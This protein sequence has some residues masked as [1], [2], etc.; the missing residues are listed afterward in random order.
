MASHDV[1]VSSYGFHAGCGIHTGKS[2]VKH[3][4]RLRHE[5]HCESSVSTHPC[6]SS[7]LV[8]LCSWTRY[9][10]LFITLWSGFTFFCYRHFITTL[11]DRLPLILCLHLGHR[12]LRCII[13][14]VCCIIL[15]RKI[16]SIGVLAHFIYHM[17]WLMLCFPSSLMIIV[18]FCIRSH[19]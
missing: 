8:N 1:P 14:V 16:T 13:I 15:L 18:L 7:I 12:L 3:N 9:H 17:K 11:L 6:K 10:L 4:A 19:G 5:L 2:W